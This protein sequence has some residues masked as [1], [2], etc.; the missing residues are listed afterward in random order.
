MQPACLCLPLIALPLLA[1][2]AF[3]ETP[4]EAALVRPDGRSGLPVRHE[5]RTTTPS[6]PKRRSTRSLP[7]GQRLTLIS[8]DAGNAGGR[9]GRSATQSSRPEHFRRQDLV[10]QLQ[11]EH[12]GRCEDSS[13]NPARPPSTVSRRCRATTRTPPKVYK[14]LTGRVTVSKQRRPPSSPS[15]CSPK[16]RSSR[17]WSRKIDSFSMKAN[18][19]PCPG[20]ADLYSATFALDVRGNAMMQPFS[21]SDHREDHQTR[22]PARR[23]DA[24]LRR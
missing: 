21:Q 22:G 7:E 16:S 12:P 19:E 10:H 2:P 17:P 24:D 14:H 20:R 3:A 18:C 5:A 11:G 13:P 1:F 4:L 23:C 15:K 9:S 6:T 8:P